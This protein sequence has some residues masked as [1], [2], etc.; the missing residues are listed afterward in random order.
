M[1]STDYLCG[2]N[3]VR[4]SR[5]LPGCGCSVLVTPG[6][7]SSLQDGGG[8][9]CRTGDNRVS[10]PVFYPLNYPAIHSAHHVTNLVQ[11]TALHVINT[12]NLHFITKSSIIYNMKSGNLE[13]RRKAI[14]DALIEQTDTNIR[15]F[16][17]RHV[18]EHP[19]DIARISSRRFKISR[20]AIGR[21]LRELVELGLLT[22]KGNTKDR[23]YKLANILN[24]GFQIAITSN[25]NESDVWLQRVAPVLKGLPENVL[26]ICN[27]GFTEMLNNVIDH[28]NSEM[29]YVEISMTALAV[30][31]IVGD[32][33][34]GIFNKIQQKFGYNDPRQALLELS[35]GKLT[36]DEK[37]HTGYG[38][39]FTS[40]AFNKFVLGSGHV[41]FLRHNDGDEWLLELEEK[42]EST[43]GTYV[44]MEIALDAKHTMGQIFDRFSTDL[45]GGFT[46]THV[47]LVLA[48]YEG[49][50]LVSRSQ[51]K[52]VL[53]RVDQFREVFLDFKDIKVIGQGFADE[54]FRVFANQRPDIDIRYV[55]AIPEVEKMIKLVKIAK[56]RS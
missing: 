50:Q 42:K 30:S 22:A 48:K 40:R 47:P 34:V 9:Q 49:E 35:K 41:Y 4:P 23:E 18:G 39:F 29:A 25:T 13:D 10:N 19:N 55:N 5:D 51:A 12:Y 31:I 44:R 43:S 7:H 16:M 32:T 21:Y 37:N 26:T 52:R 20:V 54:I 36:T 15:N 8:G 1:Y 28:S 2:C 24:V 14:V 56:N 11:I 6:N 45:D 27:W 33:G 17:L 53:I 38:I 3:P 46:K